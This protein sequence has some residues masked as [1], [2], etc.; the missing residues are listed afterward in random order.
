MEV[1]IPV[2]YLPEESWETW[3][4]VVQRFGE[5]GGIGAAERSLR[6]LFPGRR[7]PGFLASV[8]ALKQVLLE[9]W[10]LGSKLELLPTIQSLYVVGQE[11]Y[12]QVK[13]QTCESSIDMI[14]HDCKNR[15]IL[16]LEEECGCNRCLRL[17][18]DLIQGAPTVRVPNLTPHGRYSQAARIL[19]ESRV[20]SLLG[21]LPA[22]SEFTIPDLIHTPEHFVTVSQEFCRELSLVASCLNVCWMHKILTAFVTADAQGLE[23]WILRLCREFRLSSSAP[24]RDA[25]TYIAQVPTPPKPQ[26]AFLL[27]LLSIQTPAVKAINYRCQVEASKS[28]KQNAVAIVRDAFGS[29]TLT[30]LEE[31]LSL[32]EVTTGNRDQVPS[33]YPKD[34][35]FAPSLI[36]K[37]VML[38]PDIE[39]TFQEADEPDDC[40]PCCI[41]CD[42]DF[43]DDSE[44]FDESE[45]FDD[46]DGSDISEDSESNWSG[47]DSDSSD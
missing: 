46:S 32:P 22:V 30:N 12:G 17:T 41:K 42:S 40:N 21:Q 47:S 36:R 34:T 11:L 25:L 13:G 7:H 23:L 18:K 26:K 44:S 5:A 28:L 45:C 4:Y 9:P 24:W 3:G 20:R 2:P 43:S 37:S 6:A 38:I 35:T 8:V 16:I 33:Q 1:S 14:W 27:D 29:G 31:H 15:L 19:N 10:S 39:I